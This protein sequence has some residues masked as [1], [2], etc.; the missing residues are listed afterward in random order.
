MVSLKAA[1]G[2]NHL[3]YFHFLH[4]LHLTRDFVF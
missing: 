4:F 3:H 1:L 2:T